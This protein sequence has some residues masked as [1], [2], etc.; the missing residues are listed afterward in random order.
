MHLLQYSQLRSLSGVRVCACM[1][2]RSV[3]RLHSLIDLCITAAV[4]FDCCVDVAHT[5]DSVWA[6][7]TPESYANP[8]D[9]HHYGR[10]ACTEVRVMANSYAVVLIVSGVCQRACA[11][12]LLIPYRNVVMLL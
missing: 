10:A 1:C 11:H 3:I 12:R 9:K 8:M 4:N 6:T 7:F 5:I 2:V